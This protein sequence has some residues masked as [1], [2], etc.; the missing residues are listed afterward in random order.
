MVRAP[1]Y[2]KDVTLGVLVHTQLTNAMHIGTGEAQVIYSRF[3]NLATGQR[4]LRALLARLEKMLR[5][6]ER[7]QPLDSLRK[8]H[9]LLR[10]RWNARFLR[11]LILF[12]FH[13]FLLQ[14]GEAKR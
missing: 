14:H 12:L 3:V 5:V 13:R 8:F 10:R 7:G 9:L 2:L 6:Y 1:P 4:T 11:R